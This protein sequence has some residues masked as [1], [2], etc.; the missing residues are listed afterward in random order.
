M[1]VKIQ[2]PVFSR[3][4]CCVLYSPVG[5]LKVTLPPNGSPTEG[6]GGLSLA[7]NKTEK[8]FKTWTNVGETKETG[9]I[10]I[11]QCLTDCVGKNGND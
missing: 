7:Q 3:W 10:L 1:L 2:T 4:P 5:F 8:V 9:L 11:G 6:C